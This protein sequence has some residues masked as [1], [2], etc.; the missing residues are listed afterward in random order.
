MHPATWGLASDTHAA[1]AAIGGGREDCAVVSLVGLAPS[2][3]FGGGEVD[4]SEE[5]R[6]GAK[7]AD[8][9]SG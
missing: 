4:D 6:G 7:G 1:T 8:R 5:G 3:C 2:A 9:L